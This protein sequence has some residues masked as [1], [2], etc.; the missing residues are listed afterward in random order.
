MVAGC[1][2]TQGRVGLQENFVDASGSKQQPKYTHIGCA[3]LRRLAARARRQR[4]RHS[5]LLEITLL[6][7]T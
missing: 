3:A 7:Q 5:N 1:D 4:S 2:E 6:E